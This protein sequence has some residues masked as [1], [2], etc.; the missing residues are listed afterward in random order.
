MEEIFAALSALPAAGLSGLKEPGLK[1]HGELAEAFCWREP[2]TLCNRYGT[3][4]RVVRLSEEFIAS[5]RSAIACKH[6]LS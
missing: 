2:R 6:I 3:A 4:R 5:R 1:S